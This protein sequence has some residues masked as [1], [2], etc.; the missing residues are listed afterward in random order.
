MFDVNS[1]ST[2]YQYIF[3]D[4]FQCQFLFYEIYFFFILAFPKNLNPD[5]FFILILDLFFISLYTIIWLMFISQCQILQQIGII[6]LSDSNDRMNN[7]MQIKKIENYDPEILA[8]PVTKYNNTRK[9]FF[10]INT[11]IDFFINRNFIYFEDE[12]SNYAVESSKNNLFILGGFHESKYF[13]IFFKF[14]FSDIYTYETTRMPELLSKKASMY[15][16]YNSNKIY[17]IGGL[18]DGN[19]FVNLKRDSMIL[20]YLV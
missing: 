19:D 13:D 6:N 15:S 1:S 4:I 3:I 16:L 10:I 8:I 20:K 12:L 17:I 18:N 2:Y 14:C 7:S 9:S 11:K 5:T